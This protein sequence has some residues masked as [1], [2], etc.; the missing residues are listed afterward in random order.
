MKRQITLCL[1]IVL[2]CVTFSIAHRKQSGSTPASNTQTDIRKVDFLNRTYHST[3]CSQEYGRKGIGRIVRVRNGEFKTKTVYFTVASDKIVYAD[4]TGD[5]REEAI[6]R[7]D[8]GATGANFSRSEVHIYTMQNGV[9]TL[10]AGT[11]DKI[12]E[13]DYRANFRDAESYWGIN[14]NGI[15]TN[16]GNLA[17]DVL[18]DGSHAAPKYIATLEYHLS[19]RTLSLVGKPQRKSAGQ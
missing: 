9:A 12:L 8:C 5:G 13:R 17:I 15:K 1:M 7:I 14:Q 16:N 18:V 10:L 3:L 4:L 19:G 6:V 11:N 2:L